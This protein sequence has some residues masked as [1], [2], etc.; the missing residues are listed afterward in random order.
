[1]EGYKSFWDYLKRK[2]CDFGDYF[3]IIGTGTFLVGAKASDIFLVPAVYSCTFILC[4]CSNW[5]K[6]YRENKEGKLEQMIEKPNRESLN[7]KWS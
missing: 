4:G 6:E 3:L 5:I 7:N 2:K 1:M